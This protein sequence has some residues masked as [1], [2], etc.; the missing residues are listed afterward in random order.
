MRNIY[1]F[2]VLGAL[3]GW[4]PEA[5]GQGR[6]DIE[7]LDLQSLLDT[8]IASVTRREERSSLAPASVFVVPG[9]D[10][11]AHGFRTIAEVLR[12]VPGL[13]MNDDAMFPTAGVRGIN[14]LGDLT[15]RILVMVDGHPLNSSVALGQSHLERDLPVNPLALERVEVIKGPVG[16]VYGPVAYLGVVNL[17][18]RSGQGAEAI[19]GEVHASADAEQSALR[20]GEATAFAGGKVGGLRYSLNLGAYRSRGLDYAF[21]ELQGLDRPTPPGAS[22]AGTDGRASQNGYATLSYGDFDLALGWG[23]RI[24]GLPT[25]PYSTVL[26]DPRNIAVNRSGF[27]QL[28]WQR[29]L[30]DVVSL[31]ARTSYDEFRYQDSLAY[32]EPPED[33]GLFH[34]VGQDQWLS[35]ELQATVTPFAGHRDLVGVDVQLHHTLLSSS[36]DALPPVTENPEGFG[37]GPIVRDFRTVNAYAM[38]EQRLFDNRLV[39]HGG[40]TLYTHSLFGRILTPKLAGV[41]RL[42]PDDTLKAL[43]SQGFRPP[44]LYEYAFE[45]GLDFIP[46]PELLPETATSLELSYERRLGPHASVGG[47]IYQN[48]YVRIISVATVP[49]PGL[50]HPPNPEEP[51]DFRQQFQNEGGILARGVDLYFS[52]RYLNRLSA[53]GGLAVQAAEFPGFRWPAAGFAPVSGNLSVSTRWLWEPL[54]LS[55][56]L[57]FV[58]PRL[59]DATHLRPGERDQVPPYTL[60]NAAARLDVPTVDKLLVQL[61]VYNLLN[62]PVIDP[63]AGDHAPLSQLTHLG[64]GFALSV[65]YRF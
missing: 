56:S 23:Q 45:D 1:L 15:T 64:R 51:T 34:D 4:G 27:A 63:L 60:V 3:T 29:Q 53:Y 8:P 2:V 46:N 42:S 6:S 41:L 26:G 49:A 14:L 12:T 33:F 55:A 35:A 50:D 58:G 36:Y 31:Y 20:G 61:N 28:S 11:R 47:S 24:K 65:G 18:T 52:V 13:F 10:I 5:R 62:L 43:V 39:L 25:A 59:K 44:T 17:V 40:L 9:E 57:A 22:V 32:P 19:S 37:V 48:R 54:T 30:G 7:S 38:I 16:S 21:P